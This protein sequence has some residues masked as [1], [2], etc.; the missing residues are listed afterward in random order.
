ME[1]TRT[2]VSTVNTDVRKTRKAQVEAEAVVSEWSH[3]PVQVPL[4]L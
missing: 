4:T 1:T 3:V 2:L